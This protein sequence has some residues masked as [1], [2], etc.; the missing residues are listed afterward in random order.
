MIATANQGFGSAN[1]LRQKYGLTE[2]DDAT[3]LDHTWFRKHENQAGR[4]TSPDPYNGSMSLGDPQSFNRYSY[5]SN[6]PTN[7][8]DPSGLQASSGMCYTYA[9]GKEY[10]FEDGTVIRVVEGTYT[11]CTGGGGGNVGGT[12]WELGG[13]GG[14]GGGNSFLSVKYNREYWKCRAEVSNQFVNDLKDDVRRLND[15]ENVRNSEAD[16]RTKA[17]AI[18]GVIV[19]I[20]VRSIPSIITGHATLMWY[21][22]A[23]YYNQARFARDVWLTYRRERSNM[24]R[25]ERI[26]FPELYA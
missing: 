16:I 26:R 14:G 4:W 19:G 15:R 11:I 7:F 3:G 22:A 5:V 21:Q 24:E 12:G 2:R 13:G 8:V 25:C 18:I 9:Y 10:R 20:A 1:A 17:V 6:Q 23:T